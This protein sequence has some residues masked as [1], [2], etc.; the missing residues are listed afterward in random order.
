MMGCLTIAGGGLPAALALR[1][2]RV[3]Y[4]SQA[5][6]RCIKQIAGWSWPPVDRRRSHHFFPAEFTS[7]K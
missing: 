6:A 5:N 4:P 3:F 7:A 2:R 1:P